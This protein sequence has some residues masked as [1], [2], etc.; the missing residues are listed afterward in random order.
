MFSSA[1]VRKPA[2]KALRCISR[3]STQSRPRRCT[4]CLAEGESA[5]GVKARQPDVHMSL[6]SSSGVS[7]RPFTHRSLNARSFVCAWWEPNTW[8]RLPRPHLVRRLANSVGT[9]DTARTVDASISDSA[10]AAPKATA[11]PQ[12]ADKSVKNIAATFAPRAS[13]NTGKNPAVQGSVLY[14]IFTWQAWI[15]CALGGLLSYNLIFPS[16]EPDL[17]RLMGYGLHKIS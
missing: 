3:A 10:T 16:N 4:L 9:T 15:C 12:A 6:L 8:N 2:V 1:Q 14:G 11:V 13:G 5:P 17:W 7:I